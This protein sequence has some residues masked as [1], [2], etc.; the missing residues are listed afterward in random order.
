MVHRPNG[1]SSLGG[2]CPSKEA[3]YTESMAVLERH[4]DLVEELLAEVEAY[5]PDVDREL[6]ARAFDFAAQAHA[7]QVRR[8]GQEFSY[9]PW[10]VAEILAGPQPHGAPPAA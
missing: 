1:E 5:K 10:G 9:H 7:E 3:G 6:L 4:Q 8:P 2:T